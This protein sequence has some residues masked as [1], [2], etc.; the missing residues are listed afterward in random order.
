MSS[1]LE[2]FAR[3]TIAAVLR[4]LIQAATR[5]ESDEYRAGYLDA[6][7]DVGVAFEVMDFAPERPVYPRS[8]R[9]FTASGDD[10]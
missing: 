8:R 4:S 5:T 7:Q 10:A 1:H 3:G 9:M 2:V 6:L